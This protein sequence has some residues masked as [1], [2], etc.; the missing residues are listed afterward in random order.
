MPPQI[1][2]G[3]PAAT[4]PCR[5]ASA[6][7]PGCSPTRAKRRTLGCRRQALHRFRRRHRRAQHRP[8]PPEGDG[9]RARKQMERFTHTCF[10]VTLYDCYVE[11][12][13][14][15]NALAPI[16]GPAKSAL[17]ST[18]A[19]ATEN[20]I[21]IARAAT[22]RAGVIAFTG[23]FH[24]RTCHGHEHDRQG[25]ALQ[26]GHRAG[27]AGNVSRAFPAPQS[28]VTSRGFAQVPRASCSRPTSIQ[29]AS[30]RSS[31][32]RCRARAASTWRRRS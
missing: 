13:E 17:F 11:L 2:L 31:S 12:C 14:Q 21:K 23:A 32:S 27:A 4:P 10:Q 20:A 6:I 19:E 26:E 3:S 18:G 15:L 9:R 16:A 25:R 7:P 1:W 24:G 30:R 22:G 28:G 29:R 8:P 5:A